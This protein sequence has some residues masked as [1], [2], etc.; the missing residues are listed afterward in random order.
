MNSADPPS[1]STGPY[2]SRLAGATPIAPAFSVPPSGEGRVSWGTS[3]VSVCNAPSRST[4]TSVGPE[5]FRTAVSRSL[6]PE[7]SLPP[8]AT[9]SSPGWMPAASAGAG[10]PGRQLGSFTCSTVVASRT[11]DDTSDTT[12]RLSR[13]GNPIVTAIRYSTTNP[14]TKWVADQRRA[15]RCASMS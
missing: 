8:T 6:Q 11:Q 10:S 13:L 15:R 5:E 12:A 2:G 3:T 7:I 4:F 14:S 9:S 1:A